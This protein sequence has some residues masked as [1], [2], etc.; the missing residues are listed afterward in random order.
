[1]PFRYLIAE[2]NVAFRTVM[3]SSCL[4][5]SSTK[6][7]RHALNENFRYRYWFFS[8]SHG[9]AAQSLVLRWMLM[10]YG[11][12]YGPASFSLGFAL[13]ISQKRH[14]LSGVF[15]GVPVCTFRM[16]TKPNNGV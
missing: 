2:P 6:A 15:S 3:S 7:K 4:K 16:L 1:M 9:Q 12:L 5:G 10:E 11:V 8:E 14:S 13:H